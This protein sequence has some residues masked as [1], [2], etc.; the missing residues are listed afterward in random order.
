MSS[1]MSLFVY[2]SFS[3]GMI[4]RSKIENYVLESKP[5]QAFGFCYLL[6]VGY[7]TFLAATSQEGAPDGSSWV[8]GE[9]VR[10]EAPD[11]LWRL[12]DEFHGVSALV[13][14]KGLHFRQE[15]PI[16]VDG[17]LSSA[18]AYCMNPGKLPKDSRLVGNGDWQTPFAQ[19]SG[20]TAHLSPKHVDYMRK[21]SQ[22]KGREVIPY[23]LN[24]SREL[25][26]MELL[27]D[28]GRRLAL[29]KLGKEALRFLPE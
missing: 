15:V 26:K 21:L 22:T 29:T 14:E 5:A 3:S 13:P 25:M 16:K 20:I 12:L 1:N 4:H 8:Q 18:W 28:K 7:P 17:A 27:V 11:L 2:G 24:L 23:D 9:L 19:D 10:I 6:P